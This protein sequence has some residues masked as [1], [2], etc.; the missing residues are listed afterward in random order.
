MAHQVRAILKL[1]L[2]EEI[3]VG[4]SF[5]VAGN[6]KEGFKNLKT[7]GLYPRIKLPN[8]FIFDPIPVY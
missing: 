2:K 8:R 7:S 3:T 6:T 1:Y 4:N 5:F